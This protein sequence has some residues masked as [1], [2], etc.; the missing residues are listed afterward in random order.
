MSE[1]GED[2]CIQTLSRVN[3]KKAKIRIWYNSGT[4]STSLLLSLRIE[5]VPFPY[6]LLRRIKQ[7][8][9]VA[10]GDSIEWTSSI[11]TTMREVVGLIL[12][13]EVSIMVKVIKEE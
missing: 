9:Y 1:K 12:P 13:A 3:C 5:H 4:L 11:Q 6:V 2:R 10:I 8:L 7:I